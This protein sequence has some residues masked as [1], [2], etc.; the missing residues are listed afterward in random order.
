MQS[1]SSK[2]KPDIITLAIWRLLQWKAKQKRLLANAGRTDWTLQEEKHTQGTRI[3]ESY[4]EESEIRKLKRLFP[5]S[6]SA[7]FLSKQTADSSESFRSALLNSLTSFIKWKSYKQNK[8]ESEERLTNSS[9]ITLP[10]KYSSCKVKTL[11]TAGG[12]RQSHCKLWAIAHLD[13]YVTWGG[14]MKNAKSTAVLAQTV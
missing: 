4:Q 5:P 9:K 1:I 3:L 8:K 11:W 13:L 6:S 2:N 14:K 7:C 10:A 12:P